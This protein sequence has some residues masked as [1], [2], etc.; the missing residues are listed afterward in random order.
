MATASKAARKAAGKRINKATSSASGEVIGIISYWSL[1][2]VWIKVTELQA[3][4]AKHGLDEDAWFPPRIQGSTAFRKSL[5][6]VKKDKGY[7]LRPILETDEK[8]IYGVVRE[9]VDEANADLEYECE[10]KV[11]Y[12]KKTESVHTKGKGA[13]LAIADQV[14]DVFDEM[15]ETFVNWD[16]QRMLRRNIGREMSSIT[17]RR[18]GGFYFS[19]PQHLPDIEKHQAVVEDIGSSD[20]GIVVV[21]QDDKHN[22]RTVGRDTRRSL[23]DDLNEVKVELEKFKTKTPRESTLEDRLNEFKS[24]KAKCDMYASMLDIQVSDLKQGVDDCAQQVRALIG[25]VQVEKAA[26]AEAKAAAKPKAKTK[27]KPSAKDL[28]EKAKV[29]RVRKVKAA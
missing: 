10:A 28:K 11:A 15:T 5:R 26:K 9:D 2:E 22:K 25:Q 3:L 16:V 1:D 24:L 29:R 18:G 12:S 19:L 20:M 6:Q 14:K 27:A 4:F 7:I 21:K 17:L 23:E 13:A 8:I